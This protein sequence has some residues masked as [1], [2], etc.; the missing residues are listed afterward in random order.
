VYEATGA[1]MSQLHGTRTQSPRSRRAAVASRCAVRSRTAARAIAG[2]FD[3]MLAAGLVAEL[4]AFARAFALAI[5]L[6]S[7]RCVGYRQAWDSSTATSTRRARARKASRDAPAREAAVHLAALDCR[8]SPSR[9]HVVSRSSAVDRSSC[10]PQL[11]DRQLS[12]ALTARSRYAII[13]RR[14]RAAARRRRYDH[15]FRRTLVR[16]ALGQP[17]VRTEGDGTALLYIDRH[18]VHE[19]TSP[20]AFEGLRS[21][22]ASRGASGSIVATADHN[23]P[24]QDWHGHQD[25]ISRTQ[26]ETLD[27]NIRARRE[28][29]FPVPRRAPGHR[30]RDRP[31]QGATLPGMTVVCGDSHTQHARR[32]RL[33]RASASARRKSSTCS[34]PNA[35]CARSRSDAVTV[36]GALPPGV[37]AKDI[38]LAIIG[39]IGTGGGTGYAIE[40]A[41]RRSRALSMEGR[42]TVCNMAIEAGAA[43]GM[44][45]VDDTTIDYLRAARLAQARA[46]DAPSPTGAR[47]V[48]RRRAVRHASSTRCAR[49]RRR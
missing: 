6:P 38:V 34:P 47:C 2:R 44:V 42:M 49:D 26:V 40:F 5:G 32:L 23:T 15:D 19:V 31:E 24:T 43:P 10:S 20:Q 9:P 3:A 35:C 29:L 21:P 12:A 39:R 18:L 33:P 30:A 22:G 28:G 46:W 48:R 7:M 25:P 37:H 27:D 45:A 16:Q 36:D 14:C 13:I 4:E 1:P 41:A 17:V 8:R 11:V